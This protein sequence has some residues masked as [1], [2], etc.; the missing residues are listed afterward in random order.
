MT[1]I[2]LENI[3]EQIITEVVFYSSEDMIIYKDGNNVIIAT[4]EGEELSS[5]KLPIDHNN[6]E[7]IPTEDEII[8]MF[9]G[10][11]FIIVDKNTEIE[12]TEFS[13]DN[14]ALGKICTKIFLDDTKDILTFGTQR[15]NKVQSVSYS[16]S[17]QKRISQSMSWNLEKFSY[18]EVLGDRIFAIIDNTFLISLESKTN[19]V[20]F[21]RFESGSIKGKFLPTDYGLIYPYG[22]CLRRVTSDGV[23]T[24]RIPTVRVSSIE[25]VSG[26]HLYFTSNDKK[27]INCY[28][29]KSNA[30]QWEI[31][32]HNAIEES[33][34]VKGYGNG[35]RYNI[36]ILRLN[37]HIGIIN[38]DKGE[39][40]K[41]IKCPNVF[42]LRD[43]GS[44]ILAHRS[45]GITTIIPHGD[46]GV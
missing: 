16:I 5:F 36:M 18:F 23:K 31:F 1:C 35:I 41:Y 27:N 10:S 3:N 12:K 45:N 42:R 37:N 4:H 26:R 44:H 40:I 8:F 7:I 19:E 46:E 15:D 43:T 9:G 32:G 13:I 17:Q 2:N 28:D 29:M 39:S 21:N 20:L 22:H 34:V 24:A 30:L 14:L 6:F 38:L 11:H 33:L 25:H